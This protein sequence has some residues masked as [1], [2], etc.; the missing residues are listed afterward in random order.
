MRRVVLVATLIALMSPSFAVAAGVNDPDDTSGRLDIEYLG[1]HIKGDRLEFEVSMYQDWSPRLFRLAREENDGASRRGQLIVFFNTR[2]DGRAEYSLA[3][4]RDNGRWVGDLCPVV[5]G[6]AGDLYPTCDSAK[7][8]RSESDSIQFSIAPDQILQHDDTSY[9]WR[10]KSKLAFAT[11]C[12][13]TGK[14]HCVD[15]AV[16]RQAD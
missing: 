11:G 8:W 4:E 6:K 13:G 1:A 15:R 5:H 3:V 16:G 7:V 10:A 14:S 2:N 12:P 9:R